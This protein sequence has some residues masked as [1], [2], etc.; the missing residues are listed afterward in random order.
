MNERKLSPLDRVFE[1]LDQAVRTVLGP[2]PPPSRPNPA[3]ATSEQPMTDRERRHAAGLMRV[4]HAGEIMAQ[5]LYQGQALTARLE[6]VREAM[7]QAA[8]EEFDHL[9]WC[10]DRLQELKDRPSRLGPVWYTGAFL[11]GAGAG[12]A[13]DRWSLGFVSETEAQVINHLEEHLGRLPPGDRRSRAIIE[14]MKVDEAHHGAEARAAGG[15]PLPP[16]ARGL[17]AV[18]SKVMTRTAYWI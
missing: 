11:L 7:E 18:M 6:T 1:Q 15:L 16:P 17:M 10:E 3:G 12:L 2:P 9:A 8:V 5:G 4:N 14:Q 13:G